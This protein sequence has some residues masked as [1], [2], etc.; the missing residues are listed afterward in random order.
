[1]SLRSILLRGATVL[2]AGALGAGS[3]ATYAAETWTPITPQASELYFALDMPQ[4]IEDGGWSANSSHRPYRI[5]SEPRSALYPLAAI[6]LVRL[7][8]NY[9]YH[10]TTDANAALQKFSYLK[11]GYEILQEQRELATRS[12]RTSYL[13]VKF[14]GRECVVFSGKSGQGGGD[15]QVSDGTSAMLGFYCQPEAKDLKSEAV[16][17]VLNAIGTK[18]EGSLAPEPV[19]APYQE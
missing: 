9:F 14:R 15:A 12:F 13:T 1:M 16:T 4:T 7:A 17:I 18:A 19:P 2:I 5:V 3:S 8:P 11:S 10:T 6:Y